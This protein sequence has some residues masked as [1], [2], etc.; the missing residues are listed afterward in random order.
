MLARE[1]C[2]N[3]NHFRGKITILPV[4]NLTLCK[5]ICKFEKNYIIHKNPNQF[6]KQIVVVDSV[7][8]ILML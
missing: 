3:N 4:I 2:Q 5:C 7:F 6:I 8:I 1:K